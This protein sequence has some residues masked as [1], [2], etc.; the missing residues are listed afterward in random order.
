[1][2]K[3]NPIEFLLEKLT[4]VQDLKKSDGL[5]DKISEDL[6]KHYI[7]QAIKMFKKEIIETYVLSGWRDADTIRIAEQYYNETYGK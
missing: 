2:N 3:Q 5:T 7:E 6:R 4:Y 1:M